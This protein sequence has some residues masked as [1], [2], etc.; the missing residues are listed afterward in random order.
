MKVY[1]R[2]QLSKMRK[3][4][5]VGIGESFG[6]KIAYPHES[7]KKTEGYILPINNFKAEDFLLH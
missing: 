4:N 7:F 2:I 3:K 5:L 6:K 1:L